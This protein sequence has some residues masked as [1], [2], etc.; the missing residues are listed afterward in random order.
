L[1]RRFAIG[2]LCFPLI[3][4]GALAHAEPPTGAREDFV[5]DLHDDHRTYVDSASELAEVSLAREKETARLALSS[6]SPEEIAALLR[7]YAAE[8]SAIA[9]ARAAIRASERDPDRFASM[10]RR[11]R[12]RGLVPTLSVGARRGQGVDLR[13][14]T[15]DTGVRYTSGDDLVVSATLRFDLGRLLFADEEVMI[16][17]EAR[18]A[19]AVRLELVR[20]VIHWYYLRRRL[21]LERDALGHTSVMREV[22]IAEIEALLDV[23]TNGL[24]R[25]MIEGQRKEWTTDESTPGSGQKSPRKSTSRGRFSPRRLVT[26]RKGARRSSRTRSCSKEVPSP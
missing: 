17:R 13:T 20:D 26:S 4:S 12:W 22:K 25:R 24:F 11:A 5:A 14:V 9:V 16:A 23:F 18:A 2:A 19:K 15:D 10:L 21:Q 7:R 8:P 6:L 3:C 1:S